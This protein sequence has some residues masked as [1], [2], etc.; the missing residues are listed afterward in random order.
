[1]TPSLHVSIAMESDAGAIARMSRDLIEHGLPWTW[2]AG[3]VI[4]AI[5]APNMNVAVVRE[6]QKLI[7]F[8][9][10]EYWDDDAHLVLFAVRPASQRQGV[11]SAV[12]RWLEASAIVAGA[13]RVRVEARQDNGAARNFYNEHGYHELTI[14]PGMYSG[15]LDGIQL[16]KW[17]RTTAAGDA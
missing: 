14:K 4:H 3:R 1:L 11:G 10:M 15:Q 7:A 12:L 2:D 13:K 6:Q 8:G 17:F 5:T 9:I 16:E